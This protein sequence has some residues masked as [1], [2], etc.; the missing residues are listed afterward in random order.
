MT[1]AL[2]LVDLAD[3]LVD[4]LN[5]NVAFA[6]EFTARRAYLPLR[7][8]KDFAT[9]QVTVLLKSTSTKPIDRKSDQR[10]VELVVAV[11]R[12]VNPD[13]L[14]AVDNLIALVEQIAAHVNRGRLA[15]QA[16][17]TGTVIDPLVAQDHLLEQR[18]FTSILTFTY[19][20]FN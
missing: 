17:H 4:D 20:I 12:K 5:A 9:L 14:D 10:D 6:Q 1:T 13:D 19:R 8:L 18:I 3:A 16:V 15:D 11:Q 2:T 7:D